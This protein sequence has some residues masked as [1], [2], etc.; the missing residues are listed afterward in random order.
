MVYCRLSKKFLEVE[1]MSKIIA[2]YVRR[3]VSDKDKGNNS[4]SVESQISDCIKSLKEGEEYLLYC[5]D[6][7]SAKNT[8]HGDC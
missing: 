2:L 8:K 3:S 5:D 7:K 1:N 4:L 6:G